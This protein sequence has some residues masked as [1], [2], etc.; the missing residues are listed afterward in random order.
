MIVLEILLAVCAL[1]GVIRFLAGILDRPTEL[2]PDV[3][4]PD[5]EERAQNLKLKLAAW[6]AGKPFTSPR[7][8][9]ELEAAHTAAPGRYWIA[10][11]RSVAPRNEETRRLALLPDPQAALGI[12]R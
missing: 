4:V 6:K 11:D 2:D 5:L 3:W 10:D 9:A 7:A 1:F 8:L 12:G